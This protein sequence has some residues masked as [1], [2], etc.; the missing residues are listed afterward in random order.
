M[1]IFSKDNS[2]RTSL[3]LGAGLVG[4]GLA[5]LYLEGRRKKKR[6]VL[7]VD[8]DE[9]C[10]GYL[11]EFI[12][13]NNATY[14]T[15]VTTKDFHSYMFWQVDGCKL[16]SREDAT[17]R[18]YEFHA[19]PF[20][21]CK[22]LEGA[23][24]ALLKLKEKYELHVVTSRQNDIKPQTLAC[25]E[26][27]FPGVFDGVHFGNHF[28]VSGKK[29][30]KPDMCKYIGATALIDDSLDY[31]RECANSKIPTYLFGKYPWNQTDA[32]LNPLIHRV[33]NWNEVLDLLK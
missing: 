19:S 5:Y 28:G 21:D 14:G 29:T 23:C 6:P 4:L 1:S 26:R 15:T 18:V 27:Y 9:V 32:Q 2:F 31:A 11:P 20:F 33:S 10:V 3:S 17:A 30:S 24:E 16:A 7:A 12:K 25:M 8:F 13:F 22:P